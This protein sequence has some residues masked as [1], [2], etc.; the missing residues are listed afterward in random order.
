MFFWIVF[1]LAL[2]KSL[3]SFRRDI[4]QGLAQMRIGTKSIWIVVFIA[5]WSLVYSPLELRFITTSLSGLWLDFTPHQALPF[6]FVHQTLSVSLCF[7][8]IYY[9]LFWLSAMQIPWRITRNTSIIYFLWFSLDAKIGLTLGKDLA[10]V[11]LGRRQL[12][13]IFLLR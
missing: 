8:F 1:G 9:D 2:R 4:V 10:L 6:P 7:F 5:G 13:P 11:E 3:V 12:N